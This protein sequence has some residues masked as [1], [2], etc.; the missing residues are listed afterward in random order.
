MRKD[1][2]VSGFSS[3]VAGLFSVVPIYMVRPSFFR[4]QCRFAVR[5]LS[6]P[7]TGTTRAGGREAVNAFAIGAYR[8]A[9]LQPL[10]EVEDNL[11]T[12]DH[13]S[14]EASAQSKSATAVVCTENLAN[15]HCQSSAL[16]FL[17]VVA[18]ESAA[19]QVHQTALSIGLRRLQVTAALVRAI[20][21]LGGHR[22]ASEH[23]E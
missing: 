10:Q 2:I 17:D 16:S 3:N 9:I 1:Q 13:L 14:D 12:M 15:A 5:P 22:T 6:S 4:L 7:M 20:G 18:V 23:G 8:A 19:R 11:A 21:G